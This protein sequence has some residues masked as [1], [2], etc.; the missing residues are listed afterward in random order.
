MM[1][2]R[3]AIEKIAK[4]MKFKYEYDSDEEIDPEAGTWEH[5]LRRAEMEATRQYAMTITEMAEGK[6]HIGDFLPPTELSKF[7][8]TYQVFILIWLN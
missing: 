7:M 8:N 6:H 3:R 4:E 2:R 5:T 1:D